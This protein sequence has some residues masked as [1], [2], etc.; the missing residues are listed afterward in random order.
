MSP[1]HLGASTDQG[2][3]SCTTVF[4]LL[5]QTFSKVLLSSIRAYRE[6]AT[7]I[8]QQYRAKL[9]IPAEE[10][11]MVKS[12]L[13]QYNISAHTHRSASSPR[14]TDGTMPSF[15]TCNPDTTQ[16]WCRGPPCLKLGAGLPRKGRRPMTLIQPS[17][18]CGEE[19]SDSGCYPIRAQQDRAPR[20]SSSGSANEPM[21]LLPARILLLILVTTDLLAEVPA[22]GQ[23]E[24]KT[25]R[26]FGW[27]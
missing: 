13:Q 26:R 2:Q 6:P 3:N 17:I 16:A 25:C 20:R 19:Q 27:E 8:D 22:P 10:L 24:R 14:S 12:F 9:Q 1:C 5:Q 11:T 15:A 21:G 18:D 23:V 4:A 7:A